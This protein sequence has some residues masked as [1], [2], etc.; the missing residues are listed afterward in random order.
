MFG[1]A[2]S[3]AAGANSDSTF[4]DILLSEFG[5]SRYRADTGE[6][7][8]GGAPPACGWRSG[9]EFSE[10]GKMRCT[11]PTIQQQQQQQDVK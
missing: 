8:A 9:P 2:L 4:A 7:G 1:S 11:S 3:A 10:P 6:E 5:G